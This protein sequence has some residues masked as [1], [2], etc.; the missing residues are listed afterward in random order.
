MRTLLNDIPCKWF[1]P[2]NTFQFP[3]LFIDLD[4]KIASKSGGH[5]ECEFGKLF[6]TNFHHILPNELKIWRSTQ[7]WSHLIC[8]GRMHRQRTQNRSVNYELTK[9]VIIMIIL[10]VIGIH[11]QTT[12]LTLQCTRFTFRRRPGN[13]S[14]NSIATVA[15]SQ[16]IWFYAIFLLFLSL[17]VFFFANERTSEGTIC[18]SFQ[19]HLWVMREWLITCIIANS[20]RYRHVRTIKGRQRKHLQSTHSTCRASASDFDATRSDA[21]RYDELNEKCL[22]MVMDINI[23]FCLFNV[24]HIHGLGVCV[25]VSTDWRMSVYS[26]LYATLL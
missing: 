11:R 22:L 14:N 13:C 7:T 17:V 9:L 5:G 12:C 18:K 24:Q 3:K 6:Y 23:L 16:S 19:W 8:S 26:M 4:A 21:M 10:I 2:S 15:T 20:D 1:T 25:C